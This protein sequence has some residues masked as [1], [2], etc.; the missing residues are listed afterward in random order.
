MKNGE[1]IHKVNEPHEELELDKTKTIKKRENNEISQLIYVPDEKLLISSSWDSTIRI[2]D[3]SEPDES[4][5]L[6]IMSG[7]HKD[8]DI[9][10]MDYSAHLNL[11]ASGSANGMISIFDFESGKLESICL[12]HTADITCLKFADPFP[13]LV[14]ASADGT[15]CLWPVRPCYM[16]QNNVNNCIVKIINAEWKEDGT[17]QRYG[18]NAMFVDASYQEGITKGP[19]EGNF[20]TS[21]EYHDY[22]KSITEPAKQENTNVRLGNLRVGKTQTAEVVEKERAI[23]GDEA[24]A[25]ISGLLDENFYCP[26]H[27]PPTNEFYE[28]LEDFNKYKETSELE[29]SQ[30]KHRCIIYFGDQ[31]GYMSAIDVSHILKKRDINPCKS[32]KRSDSYQLRRKEWVDV[33]KSV[34]TALMQSDKLR[35][36]IY[37]IHAFNT[38]LFKRW[39]AHAQAINHISRVNEPVCFITCST[40][41]H[42]KVWNMDGACLGDL[43]LVKLGNA[44]W[45][46]PFDWVKYKLKDIDDVFAVMRVIE[47]EET[48]RL[49]KEDKDKIKLKYLMNSFGTEMDFLNAYL[50]LEDPN[51]YDRRRLLM[52]EKEYEPVI[53]RRPSW[54]EPS[55]KY[56]EMI[57]PERKEPEMIE[58]FNFSSANFK[59]GE[60]PYKVA[61]AIEERENKDKKDGIQLPQ[62]SKKKQGS[63]DSRGKFSKAAQSLAEHYRG[64]SSRPTNKSSSN[65]LSIWF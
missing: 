20:P 50:G 65:S 24:K 31:K 21:K 49:T 3:E 32:Q 59:E 46:L 60:L 19:L 33:S 42:V 11:L 7:A 6:R 43:N 45:N 37:S 51:A 5:L 13:I 9:I 26:L 16:H 22:V 36:P 52:Q 38:V 61:K 35:K 41:K 4:M 23:I 40:D 27:K 58:K 48:E 63:I 29:I 10:V 39:E 8:S 18:I 2:Y 57:M 14:S 44:N 1:P 55:N 17:E 25:L 15:I 53:K 47:K 34:E 56:K 62:G 28:S 12:G 64:Y 30:K 54:L